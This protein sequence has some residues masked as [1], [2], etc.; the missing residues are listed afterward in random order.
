MMKAKDIKWITSTSL[1]AALTSSGAFAERS[2]KQ[3]Y[4]NSAQHQ[5]TVQYERSHTQATSEEEWYDPRDWF[6]GDKIDHEPAGDSKSS[7]A[8]WQQ[9]NWE[10]NYPDSTVLENQSQTRTASGY[11]W[12]DEQQKWEKD[13]SINSNENYNY[14]TATTNVDGSQLRTRSSQHSENST[15][16]DND[17]R[18][19]SKMKQQHLSGQILAFRKMNLQATDAATPTENI[20]AKVE[21]NSGKQIVM[22]LGEK[23]SLDRLELEKGDS[24]ELSG[25]GGQVNGEPLFIVKELKFKDRTL[26]VNRAIQINNAS[27]LAQNHSLPASQNTNSQ[28]NEGVYNDR[29]ALS[30]ST[31]QHA[32]IRGTVASF[33]LEEK[34]HANDAMRTATLKMD[35][36]QSHTVA[37]DKDINA[38]LD[39]LNLEPGDLIRIEG[40]HQEM[41][42]E[43]LVVI[44]RIW[45]NGERPQQFSANF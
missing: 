17:H 30:N 6:D 33:E 2:N 44:E 5:N 24:I 40:E 35:S 21:L 25:V 14:G 32:D 20:V 31:H 38:A 45:I 18:S 13:D 1:I 19:D 43:E 34:T 7:W 8:F 11:V 16:R 42:G 27:A 12:N 22:S 9:D 4:E 28:S 23:R 3:T 41:H 29:T 26:Q 15:M 37:I 39:Q 36:G 10:D